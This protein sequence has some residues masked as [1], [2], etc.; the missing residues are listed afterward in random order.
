VTALNKDYRLDG[1]T[2]QAA[3]EQG[4]A[5][6]NW[7]QC[8]M[9]RKVFKDLLKR[10]DAKGFLWIGSWVAAILAYLSLG[11]PWAVLAFMLYGVLYSVSD[12]AAHELSHGTP[13]KTAKIN[14]FF[15]VIA[16]FLTLHEPVYWRWSHA[17][18]HTDTLIVGR[19]RE[20][21]FPTPFSWKN[22]CLDVFFLQSGLTEIG[23]IVQHAWGHVSAATRS[24]VPEQEIPR[25]IRSSRLY[26][27][28]FVALMATCVLTASVI[29]AL[30]V[31]LPRFY[32][33]QLA[34]ILN[35]TQHAGLQENV[36]DHRQNC[37]TI[38]LPRWLAFLYMNMNYHLEHHMFP[39]VPLHSLPDLHALMVSQCPK[40]YESLTE[41]YK[42]IIPALRRQAVDPTYF[43]SRS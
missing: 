8:Q 19:D 1:P 30:F 27:L 2:G 37:R 32:A 14:H 21:A 17:R 36:L 22:L 28:I 40:P 41:A 42:E 11:T 16:S 6:A 4:L 34:L 24:F 43:A 18:H 20:I 31:V 25:M 39:L 5:S 38:Y 35:I 26:T 10:S 9:D 7:F 13:F 15:Y 23:R 12:H 33:G 3:I 29:P